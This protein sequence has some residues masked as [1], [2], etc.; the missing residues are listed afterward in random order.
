MMPSPQAQRMPGIM[1]RCRSARLLLTL[2]AMAPTLAPLGAC[3]ANTGLTNLKAITL[4]DG[5]NTVV[6]FVPDGRVGLIVAAHSGSAPTRNDVFVVLL[7]SPMPGEGWN[8]V[9][10]NAGPTLR[11]TG[12]AAVQDTITA[13]QDGIP[14]LRAVRFARGKMNGIPQTFLLSA[15]KD[16]DGRSP[17]TLEIYRLSEGNRTGGEQFIQVRQFRSSRRYCSAVDALSREFG[18][19]SDSPDSAC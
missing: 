19:P 5:S 9:S 12:Q 13:A 15:M 8:I 16:G 17:V 1:R 11:G 7:P 3:A 4:R 2:L 14:G 10:I 18:L 6:H